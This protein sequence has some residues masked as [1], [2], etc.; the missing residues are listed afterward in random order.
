MGRGGRRTK[1]EARVRGEKGDARGSTQ[2][3][4]R[5]R[6]QGSRLAHGR[7]PSAACVTGIGGGGEGQGKQSRE[8]GEEEEEER[9]GSG[10]SREPRPIC[11]L[12]LSFFFDSILPQNFNL[13]N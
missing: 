7:R 3:G 6:S 11:P 12:F 8:T 9:K 4:R 2:R 5:S 1:E 10:V 13:L